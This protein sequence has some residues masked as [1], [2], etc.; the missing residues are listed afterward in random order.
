MFKH[1][2]LNEEIF[3]GGNI[4]ELRHRRC[5]CDWTIRLSIFMVFN[6]TASSREALN[7]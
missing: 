7:P 4:T 3:Y 1:K 6:C 2:K 5:G